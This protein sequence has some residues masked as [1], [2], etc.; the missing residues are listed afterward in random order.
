M[1]IKKFNE[2]VGRPIMYIDMDGVLCD[3]YNA[4]RKHI[5]ENPDQKFPQSKLG[6]FLN[7]KPMEGAIDAFKKLSEKYDVWILTRP[8]SRNVNCYS[9]RPNGFG[10]I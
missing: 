10:I 9:E 2:S 8:S 7:L 4:A 5:S 3:F 1:K 6:F